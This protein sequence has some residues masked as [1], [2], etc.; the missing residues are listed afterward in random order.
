MGN[1]N[2]KTRQTLL[3]DITNEIIQNVSTTYLFDAGT[4]CSIVQNVTVEVG[5]GSIVRG[6]N[7]QSKLSAVQV[8]S[9]E[10]KSDAQISANLQGKI[11]NELDQLLKNKQESIQGF[12]ATARANQE[13]NGQIQNSIEN[14]AKAFVETNVATKCVDALTIT[15]GNKFI[16]SNSTWECPPGGTISFTQDAK[17]EA[18]NNCASNLLTNAILNNDFVNKIISKMESE[19]RA[20]QEG[21]SLSFLIAILLI[22]LA[23]S[24]VVLFSSARLLAP[25]RNPKTGMVDLLPWAVNLTI[26]VIMWMILITL[27]VKLWESIKGYFK[28]IFDKLNPVNWGK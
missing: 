21:I 16:L 17:Q 27:I 12:L 8:C 13:Y 10:A 1:V 18:A 19:Q 3:N 5:Q 22:F 15:Q 28:K 14:I 26:L 7:F 20:K 11:E 25:V 24:V 9:L 2:Q 6:C 23:P 4:D